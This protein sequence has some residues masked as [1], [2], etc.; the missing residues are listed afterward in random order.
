[1]LTFKNISIIIQIIKNL[2]TRDERVVL[3]ISRESLVA[4]KRSDAKMNHTHRYLTHQIIVSV[5]YVTAEFN[6]NS[7][8]LVL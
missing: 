5:G 7:L 4:G 8:R 3:L 2:Q 6:I 1:M